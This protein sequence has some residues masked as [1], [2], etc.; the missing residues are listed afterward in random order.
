MVPG[1]IKP[2]NT[3]TGQC[4]V[5]VP[6]IRV[7]F[8]TN[9][10]DNVVPTP[11]DASGST[12]SCIYTV[13]IAVAVGVLGVSCVADTFGPVPLR[14]GGALLTYS[15][16][17]VLEGN[18]ALAS[19]YCRVPDCI[20]RALLVR[21][22]TTAG[23]DETRFADA[24]SRSC[25]ILAVRNTGKATCTRG[26]V[27]GRTDTNSVADH[28]SNLITDYASS[29]HCISNLRMGAHTMT[30][31]PDQLPSAGP[32]RNTN[33]VLHVISI[34]A[35]TL[36]KRISMS[37]GL[38]TQLAGIAGSIKRIAIVADTK[39]VLI[40]VAIRRTYHTVVVDDSETSW[41]NAV[42][43]HLHEIGSTIDRCPWD[44]TVAG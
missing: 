22:A 5:A 39:S 31:V 30:A 21:S 1:A 28:S 10:I 16:D 37:I 35:S 18:C 20:L 3:H 25:I 29:C 11:A 38:T 17:D 14:I 12:P 36:S 41:A 26:I 27:S 15:I 8:L 43:I 2:I 7:T 6:A 33:I 32:L 24:S 40:D 42:S 19:A 13:F 23:E 4:C 34:V 44:T 9:S